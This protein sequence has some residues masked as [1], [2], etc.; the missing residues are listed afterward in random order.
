MLDNFVL[1]NKL[2]A[3]KAVL[4]ANFV[5]QKNLVANKAVLV[6][7]FALQKKLVASQNRTELRDDERN[8]KAHKSSLRDLMRREVDGN[9][10]GLPLMRGIAKGFYKS[11]VMRV[12]ATS[13]LFL[14]Y[15]MHQRVHSLRK[16]LR[17]PCLNPHTH[18]FVRMKIPL[19]KRSDRLRV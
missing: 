5:L 15:V 2:V 11:A 9:P 1:Q 12:D 3:N 10:R 16:K 17:L 7:N 4:V 13:G 19:P 18:A 8:K 14:I 6:A